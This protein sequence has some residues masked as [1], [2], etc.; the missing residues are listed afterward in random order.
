MFG[1]LRKD[2]NFSPQATN[3]RGTLSGFSLVEFMVALAILGIA[4]L[5]MVSAYVFSWKSNVE[6]DRRATAV[7]LAR[8]KLERLRTEKGFAGIS[9]GESETTEVY[10]DR[11]DCELPDFYHEQTN[12]RYECRVRARDYYNSTTGYEVKEITLTMYFPSVFGG[13][14]TVQCRSVDEC[15]TPDFTTYFANLQSP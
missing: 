2:T 13:E 11:S 12:I 9:A 10:Q 15:E 8:W 6:A 7:V 5:P 3:T 1:F 4:I 14:R